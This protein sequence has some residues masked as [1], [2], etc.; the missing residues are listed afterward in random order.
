MNQIL[1]FKKT[2]HIKTWRHKGFPL[3]F[4]FIL[5]AI[6][7]AL[8][9]LPFALPHPSMAARLSN[10]WLSIY[11]GKITQGS[12]VLVTYRGPKH[13]KPEKILWNHVDFPFFRNDKGNYQA[14]LGIPLS[15]RQRREF[16]TL[17]VSE[18][19]NV[20]KSGF[21]LMIYKKRFRVRNL[22]LPKKAELSPKTI[23]KIKI[24]RET[25]H[26]IMSRL[27]PERL[28]HGHFIKPVSGKITSP[29]G[30]RR[31]INGTYLSIHHGVDFRASLKPPVRAINSGRVVFCDR[32]VLSGLTVVI[33]HGKGLYSLYAHLSE[34]H[35]NV[36]DRV[37]KG[38]IIGMSGNTGRS[39][40]PHLH[41]G[42][43]ICGISIDPISLIHL[44]L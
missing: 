21:G 15:I 23:E 36:N 8:C 3:A 42:V 22:Y 31:K 37:K 9:A 4:Y 43:T 11:P 2:F 25:L 14:F 34:S 19:K 5:I 30:A 26:Q 7:F 40:G 44:P 27:S 35:V 13:F 10:P 28:W 24:E 1:F 16:F 18:H 6:L 39:T 29:F 12:L 38:Q 41:L 33:D 32:M 17:I 20:R